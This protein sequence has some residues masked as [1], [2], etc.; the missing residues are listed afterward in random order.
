MTTTYAEYKDLCMKLI[1]KPPTSVNT[2]CW[3]LHEAINLY[4]QLVHET[5]AY[6]GKIIMHA[7][8]DY[9]CIQLL[10]EAGANP[11]KL[12]LHGYSVLDYAIVNRAA[13]QVIKLLLSRGSK[14]GRDIGWQFYH[15][16]DWFV[17]DAIIHGLIN[18]DTRIGPNKLTPVQYA[19]YGGE[20][21]NIYSLIELGGNPNEYITEK[22]R[23]ESAFDRI[24]G[25][26]HYSEVMS[27]IVAIGGIV[28]I[29][30]IQ[31]CDNRFID[32]TEFCIHI[33]YSIVD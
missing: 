13:S 11:N 31:W 1:E 33:L 25:D 22:G 12:D 19:M 23:T 17:V 21:D 3:R 2:N 6:S 15:V 29:R 24:I 14:F 28:P 5:H 26:P 8:V 10:L 9:N 16:G 18:F 4:P 30:L 32:N 7:V 20:V 27:R